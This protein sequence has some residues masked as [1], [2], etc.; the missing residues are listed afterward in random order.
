MKDLRELQYFLGVQV[1]RDRK[2]RQLK[3]HQRGHVNAVLERFGMQDS[4]PVSTPITMEQNF[5]NSQGKR[6]STRNSTGQMSEARCTLCCAHVRI[7]DTPSHESSNFPPIHRQPANRRREEYSD[8]SMGLGIYGITF[9][10][11]VGLVLIDTAMQTGGQERTGNRSLAMFSL[12]PAGPISWLSKKQSTTALSTTE[13]EYITLVQACLNAFPNEMILDVD[14]LGS[15]MIFWIIRQGYGAL[16][17]AVEDVVVCCLISE[18]FEEALDPHGF[19]S[20]KIDLPYCP[21]ADMLAKMGVGAVFRIADHVCSQCCRRSDLPYRG[22]DRVRRV[23]IE[24][25]GQI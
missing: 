23:Q 6:Q 20:G 25:I 18:F 12:W 16:I 21:T 4:S 11:K 24:K 10:G 2:N 15:C 22:S 13:A 7:S 8:I 17:G 3:I 19:L 14:M 5:S 9:N 1:H